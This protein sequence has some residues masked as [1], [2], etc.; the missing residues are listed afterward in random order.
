MRRFVAIVLAALLALGTVASPAFAGGEPLH[1]C[2]G[3]GQPG[4][5]GPGCS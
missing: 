2:P 1:P 4:A 3:Q 5:S